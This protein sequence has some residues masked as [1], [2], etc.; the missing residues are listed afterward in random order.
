M[1]GITGE[2]RLLTPLLAQLLLSRLSLS[3][4]SLDPGV[5]LRVVIVLVLV[6]VLVV[7]SFVAFLSRSAEPTAKGFCPVWW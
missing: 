4:A 5:D 3:N 1:L 6:V 2:D 7:V